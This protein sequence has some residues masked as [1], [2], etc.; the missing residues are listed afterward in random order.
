L[1]APGC[2]T[3]VTW[4][5]ISVVIDPVEGVTLWALA[6][7]GIEVRGETLVIIDPR[8]V[9][10]DATAAVMPPVFVCLAEALAF[11]G[12]PKAVAV[13]GVSRAVLPPGSMELLSSDAPTIG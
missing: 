10:R 4:L 1:L 7:F 12:L 6:Q 5:V 3:Q 13:V 9:H 2:P 11:D 8:L